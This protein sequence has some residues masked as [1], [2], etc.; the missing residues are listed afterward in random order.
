M[1]QCRWK[2]RR[3]PVKVARRKEEG[4]EGM[5]KD[6][7]RACCAAR[8]SPPQ[9]FI[10][11]PCVGW[12]AKGWG[13]RERGVNTRTSKRE[14]WWWWRGREGG[15]EREKVA[16]LS[17]RP[18]AARAAATPQISPVMWIGWCT[19]VCV[20]I[21][22]AS[23]RGLQRAGG[24]TGRFCAAETLG[25]LQKAA[26]KRRGRGARCCAGRLKKPRRRDAAPRPLTP[27]TPSRSGWR[28]TRRVRA[29]PG[30]EERGSG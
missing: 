15:G 27:S 1:G 30:K 6:C 13:G 22:S 19:R 7:P 17:L 21:I 2:K 5:G 4:E 26:A 16:P 25:R 23:A 28:R 9:C 8:L 14:W 20:V 12:A 29:R 10:Q 3:A 24:K 18:F 11:T